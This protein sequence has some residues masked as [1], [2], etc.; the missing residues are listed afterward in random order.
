VS[1]RAIVQLMSCAAAIAVLSAQTPA[2]P[3][4]AGAPGGAPASAPVHLP[5]KPLRHL[6]YSFAVDY[7]HAGEQNQGGIGTAGS[8]VVSTAHGSGRVGTV[9]IDVMGVGK[10]G[11]LVIKTYEWLQST[12]NP[13]QSYICAVFSEGRVVCPEHLDVTDAEN[14]LMS[15]FGRTF[16][17]PSIIDE[18]GHWTRTFANQYVSVTSNYA[19]VGSG[20]ANPLT[21]DATTKITSIGGLS[22]NWDDQARLTYD[23]TMTIPVTLHDVAIQHARGSSSMQSTM[24]FKLTKDSFAH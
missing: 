14:E 22:S 9:T 16:L 6:E 10:D 17:D 15:Y 18:T 8:G 12:P 24:D 23:R 11:G 4:P 13:T 5:D 20:D 1:Q 19:V 2:T 7:Q 21:I 3:A